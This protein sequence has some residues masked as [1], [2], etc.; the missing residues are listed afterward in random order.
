MAKKTDSK[1][2]PEMKLARYLA[3]AFVAIVAANLLKGDHQRP[4]Y[5][6]IPSVVFTIPRWLLSVSV[7]AGHVSKAL[8]SGSR[9]R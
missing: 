6:G 9:R 2:D 1:P 3:S 8:S 7:N 4:D 5:V